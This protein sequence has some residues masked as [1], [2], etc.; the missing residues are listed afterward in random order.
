[1]NTY[2]GLE[3]SENKAFN[4]VVNIPCVVGVTLKLFWSKLMD[5]YRLSEFPSHCRTLPGRS[6]FTFS[7]EELAVCDRGGPP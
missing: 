1:M 7:S 5:L 3:D 4:A 2:R 6:W